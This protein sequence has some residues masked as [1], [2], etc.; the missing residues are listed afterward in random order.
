LIQILSVLR[1]VPYT[2]FDTMCSLARESVMRCTAFALLVATGLAGTPQSG[3][4]AQGIVDLS[5]PQTGKSRFVLNPDMTPAD[6]GAREPQQPAP[7]AAVARAPACGEGCK[8]E[9]PD[10][11]REKRYGYRDEPASSRTRN[12]TRVIL[13][14]NFNGSQPQQAAKPAPAPRKTFRFRRR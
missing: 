10:V 9:Q 14:G 6:L 11:V 8:M 4:Q 12:G 1:P 2:V 3:A 7:V 13:I 5:K